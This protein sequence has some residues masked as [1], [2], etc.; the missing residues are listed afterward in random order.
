MIQGHYSLVRTEDPTGELVLLGEAKNQVRQDLDHEDAE[1]QAFINTAYEKVEQDA[2][3]SFLTQTWKLTL[4]RWPDRT[5]FVPMP[6]LQSVTS[7]T[8]VDSAG[9]SNTLVEGTD[10]DVDTLSEPGRIYPSYNKVWPSARLHENAITLIYKAGYGANAS[11][12]PK[13]YKQA[14]LLLITH[15]YENRG[16]LGPNVVKEIPEA[17]KVLTLCDRGSYIV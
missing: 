12:V 13:K 11:D 3:R 7:L 9:D 14:M 16:I 6:P 1:I 8:Y 17:Y 4:D 15:W 2:R 5:L 10:Y